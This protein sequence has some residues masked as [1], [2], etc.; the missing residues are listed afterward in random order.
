MAK[1]LALVWL[2]ILLAAFGASAGDIAQFA[3]LG[4]SPDSKH[5]M[6]GQYGT[7]EK[8]S[9]AW[10]EV[11]IVDVAKNAF[12]PKG[13]KRLTSGQ[14]LEPGASPLGALLNAVAD[15]V[16]QKKQY[17]IDHLVPGR[18]LYVLVDGAPASDTLEFRDFPSGRA[19]KIALT[20]TSAVKANVPSSSFHLAITVTDREGKARSFAAGDFSYRRS[21]VKSYAIKQIVVAPDGSSLVFIIQREEQDGNGSN[22][23]YMVETLR[24]N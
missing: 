3:N 14:P 24:T 7:L 19:Y 5:F 1:R 20:Q 17:R 2:M 9:A 15:L 12:V 6:F 21:G 13:I 8:G 22:I 4:F 23:R 10:A 18:L 11:Y 16:P